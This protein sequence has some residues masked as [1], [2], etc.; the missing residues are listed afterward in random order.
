MIRRYARYEHE[1][2]P[3]KLYLNPERGIAF[4][5]CAGLSDYFGS[6][7][8]VVRLVFVLGT[9]FTPL[10]L[11]AYLILMIVLAKRPPAVYATEGE[12]EFWRSV[13]FTPKQTLSNIKHRF[14]RIDDRIRKMEHVVTSREFE[15]SGDYKNL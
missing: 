5:V 3:H 6:S 2:G 8:S 4:G 15:L 14:R 11:L 10:F 13:R 7:V 9:L 12:E 1:G